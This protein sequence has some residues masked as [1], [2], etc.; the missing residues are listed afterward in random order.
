MF[1]TQTHCVWGGME[2][3]VHRFG[4]WLQARGWRVTAG[5]AKGSRFSDADAYHGAHPHL[6][7]FVMDG[8]VATDS[9]RIDAVAN[10][11]RRADPDVVIP[12]GIGAALPAIR[13]LKLA[14]HRARLVVPVL[15]AWPEW[16]ANILDEW[17]AID[18][19]VPNA[20]LLENFLRRRLE[21]PDRVVY[22]R[23]SVPRAHTLTAHDSP[24][25]RAAFVGRLEDA[26]KR[27]LDLIPLADALDGANV[28][29]HVFGEGPD[30]E[31]LHAGLRGRAVFHGFMPTEQLYVEAFPKLD[32]LLMF[33]PTEGSPNT[34]YEAMQHGVV[35]V[36]SRFLGWASER[37]VRDGENALTF[38]VGATD[39]AAR[40]LDA[41]DHDRALLARLGRNA[42]ESVAPFTDAD[43]FSEWEDVI[44]RA[45]MMPI[46]MPAHATRAVPAGRL[47]RVLPSVAANAVRRLLKPPPRAAS[48]WEEWPGSQ[49]AARE[50]CDAITRELVELDAEAGI[51]AYGRIP[52]Q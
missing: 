6:E 24:R 5:L 22:V 26:S 41:L 46:R 10:A 44:T 8:R 7:P 12:I 36:S 14:G 51:E 34:V 11:I 19:A 30:E 20:R 45:A 4:E 15:S 29:L 32:A 42:I 37:I 27:V 18:L 13:R 33:S 52:P 16:L 35:P 1:V 21:E 38:P 39:A 50:R 40:H 28:E 31:A 2:W 17:D 9:A 25:L 43:M 23:Q 47:D 3:W 49:P 48:G